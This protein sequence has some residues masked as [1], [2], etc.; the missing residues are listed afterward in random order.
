MSSILYRKENNVGY[1]TLNEPERSNAMSTIIKRELTTILREVRGDYSVRALVIEAN[2]KNFCAGGDIA[3]MGDKQAHNDGRERMRMA[4]DWLKELANLEKP[5]IAAVNGAAAGGGLSLALACDF[6]VAADNAKFCCSFINISLVADMGSLYFL[7]RR[8]GMPAAKNLAYTGRNV[9]AEEALKLGLADQV[10][11]LSEL[12]TAAKE[13]AEKL[14][15]GPTYS[16]GMTKTLIN[17]SFETDF[18]TFADMEINFQA[19]AFHTIDHHAA[20]RAFF[21]KRKPEFI[22][23]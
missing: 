17:K 13:I 4:V 3:T 20:V 5:T 7:P 14:A 19:A 22:G 6:I 12:K 9:E 8:V 1:I 15:I 21:E 11:S 16:I 18:N 23:K 10:V 2:G